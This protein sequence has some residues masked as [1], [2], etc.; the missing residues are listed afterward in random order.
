MTRGEEISLHAMKKEFKRL[1][2]VAEKA[3][4]EADEATHIGSELLA[5][6]QE[7][8]EIVKAKETG[9]KV[10]KKLEA[11]QKRSDRAKKIQKKSIVELMDKQIKAESDCESL[12]LEI[13]RLEFR[14][15]MRKSA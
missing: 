10:L 13:Q 8:A 6:H 2:R 12:G 9:P 4:Q 3:K 14:H 15:S 7:F 1:S 11:L 5:I